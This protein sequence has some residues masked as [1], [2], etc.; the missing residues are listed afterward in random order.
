MMLNDPKCVYI[1]LN[2]PTG[3]QKILNQ[4]KQTC[5]SSKKYK[6]PQMSPNEPKCDHVCLNK[7]KGA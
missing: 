4:T 7:L 1:I 2:E 5:M 3:D 6:S